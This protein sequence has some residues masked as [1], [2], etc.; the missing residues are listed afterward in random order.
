MPNTTNTLVGDCWILH[1]LGIL[2]RDERAE[3]KEPST[4]DVHC[5]SFQLE[6]QPVRCSLQSWLFYSPSVLTAPLY[7]GGSHHT[8]SKISRRLASQGRRTC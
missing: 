5:G 6:K 2:S 3:L 4:S 7:R 1:D 8:Y